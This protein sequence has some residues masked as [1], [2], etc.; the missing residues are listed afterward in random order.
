MKH[1]RIKKVTDGDKTRYYPQEKFLGLFWY[2]MF[3]WDGYSRGYYN[4]FEDAQ[5]ILCDYLRKPTVEY[6]D[7]NCG[8]QND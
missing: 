3:G 8:E 7:V 2:D 5:Y 6:L 1:Y 4:T